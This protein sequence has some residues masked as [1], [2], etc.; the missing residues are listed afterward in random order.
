M[1]FVGNSRYYKPYQALKVKFAQ[2]CNQMPHG[3]H[4]CGGEMLS[5]DLGSAIEIR[6]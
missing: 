6:P 3:F 1:I 5:Y 4:M 2:T